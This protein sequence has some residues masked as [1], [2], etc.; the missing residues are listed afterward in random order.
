MNPDFLV[1]IVV[2]PTIFVF[3]LAV[4]PFRKPLQHWLHR[5]AEGAEGGLPR[6]DLAEHAERLAEAERRI[7]ELE[8]RLDFAE[9]LLSRGGPAPEPRS[10]TPASG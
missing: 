3:I 8:E 6:E 5:K 1:P 7:I 9:R 2:I 4:G 10:K